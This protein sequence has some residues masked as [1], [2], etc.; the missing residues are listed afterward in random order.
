[1]HR[2][3]PVGEGVKTLVGGRPAIV[4]EGASLHDAS[5]VFSGAPSAFA[6]MRH[7]RTAVGI[8]RS[9]T[10]LLLVT[11]D[12]RQ[13]TS[14]GMSLQELAEL[15]LELGA[16]DA[17]NLDGGGSTTAVV[18][19]EIASSPSDASG[20]RTVANALLLVLRAR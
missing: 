4:A 16:V 1:M 20:E 5:G 7:P 2:F 13:E 8:G 14:V 6:T 19:G 18:R 3:A 17:L 10:L 12:G 9:G 11:V 15:M